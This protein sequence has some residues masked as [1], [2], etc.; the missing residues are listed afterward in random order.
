MVLLDAET[1]V[2]GAKEKVLRDQVRSYHLHNQDKLPYRLAEFY[3]NFSDFQRYRAIL[4]VDGNSWSERFPKLLCSNSVVI[5]IHPDQVDY[6]WPTL[7]PAYH[8]LSATLQNLSEVVA[9]AVA[10][11][12]QE[13][14]QAMVRR[15]RRWCQTFMVGFLH[16]PI[17]PWRTIALSRR[18][19]WTFTILGLSQHIRLEIIF[20]RTSCLF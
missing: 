20:K 18:S 8:F 2:G 7:V 13:A 17:F 9:Y 12:H 14:M 1:K 4:D 10:D 11:E 16:F 15:A 19:G 3:M 6:F 5:K